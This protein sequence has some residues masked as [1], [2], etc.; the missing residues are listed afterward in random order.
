MTIDIP[1]DIKFLWKMHAMKR[2]M[3]LRAWLIAVTTDFIRRE[4]ALNK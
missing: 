1:E 4:E 3:T 2:H